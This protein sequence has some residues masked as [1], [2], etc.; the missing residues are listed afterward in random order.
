VAPSLL[1]G[2][3][4]PLYSDMLPY[5][6]VWPNP[7]WLLADSRRSVPLQFLPPGA[8]LMEAVL[9]SESRSQTA[10]FYNVSVVLPTVVLLCPLIH[11]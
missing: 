4:P 7:S 10:P 6:S 8:T 9:I 1:I 3:K 2:L 5:L 11:T